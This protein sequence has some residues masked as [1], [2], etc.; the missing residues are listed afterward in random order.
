LP[1]CS[2]LVP[3]RRI[4]RSL[5]KAQGRDRGRRYLDH[6]CIFDR[7]IQMET[8]LGEPAVPRSTRQEE[9]RSTLFL[10]IVMAPVLAVIAVAGYGFLVW[11]VQLIAG[12]PGQ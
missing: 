3:W 6:H 1:V 8:Q 2:S 7:R 10:S 11:M 5:A 9:L 4:A 12:P